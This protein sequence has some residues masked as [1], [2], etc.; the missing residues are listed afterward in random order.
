MMESWGSRGAEG[1]SHLQMQMCPSSPA[2]L[3]GMWDQG[4]AGTQPTVSPQ[5]HS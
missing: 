5:P 1:G 4:A 3:Q 2:W